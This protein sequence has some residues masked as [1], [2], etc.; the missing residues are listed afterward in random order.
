MLYWVA[1]GKTSPEI[2]II[3]GAALKTVKKHLQHIYEKLGVETRTSAALRASEV[4]QRN[5]AS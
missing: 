5:G 1:Q 4:L 3:L 2:A